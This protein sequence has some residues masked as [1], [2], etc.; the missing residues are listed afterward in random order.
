MPC[1]MV[2]T[3]W[4]ARDEEAREGQHCMSHAGNQAQRVTE[5]KSHRSSRALTVWVFVSA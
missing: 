4:E 1:L 2:G 5:T 3:G